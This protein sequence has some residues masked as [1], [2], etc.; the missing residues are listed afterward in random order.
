M[1]KIIYALDAGRT[2]TKNGVPVLTF[3]RQTLSPIDADILAHRIVNAL[4]HIE[5]IRQREVQ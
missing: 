3:A 2:L 5:L 1:K 4:N